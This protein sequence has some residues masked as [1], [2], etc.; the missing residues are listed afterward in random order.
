MLSGSGRTI[1]ARLVSGPAKELSVRPADATVRESGSQSK[2]AA[3]AARRIACFR[4]WAPTPYVI[5]FAGLATAVTPWLWPGAA[6]ASELVHSLV[7]GSMVLFG[8]WKCWRPV[9]VV[10]EVVVEY[11]PRFGTG[12][13]LA[14]SELAQVLPAG[15]TGHPLADR[16]LAA[17][18]GLRTKAGAF[19]WL[20]LRELRARDRA[21]VRALLERALLR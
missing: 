8:L 5:A 19:H 16:D 17:Q 12:L 1:F 15:R 3:P 7:G 21:R 20:D 2:G 13:R 14:R 6:V 4:P 9:V 10:G 11:R 18:L